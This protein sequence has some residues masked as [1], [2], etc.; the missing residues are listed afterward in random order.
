MNLCYLLISNEN[1]E[2][3]ILD[4][5]LIN[6]ISTYL[7]NKMKLFHVLCVLDWKCEIIYPI[8]EVKN[9]AKVPHHKDVTFLLLLRCSYYVIAFILKWK[10]G[11]SPDIHGLWHLIGVSTSKD[12]EEIQ[13]RHLHGRDKKGTW[14]PFDYRT[15]AQRYSL[16]TSRMIFVGARNIT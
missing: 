6:E 5:K 10:V 4:G 11:S 8:I 9:A 15:M 16:W 1:G 12:M 14:K 13:T 7:K 3:K 2:D